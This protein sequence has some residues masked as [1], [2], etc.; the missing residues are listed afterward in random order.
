MAQ[1][2]LC[3]LA[4]G[5][6]GEIHTLF[7]LRVTSINLRVKGFLEFYDF[8]NTTNERILTNVYFAQLKAFTTL[9]TNITAS[10]NLSLRI[11][12]ST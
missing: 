7:L 12:L 1:H 5:G 10:L 6:F 9:V 8:I 4:T 3:I 11:Y 2:Y